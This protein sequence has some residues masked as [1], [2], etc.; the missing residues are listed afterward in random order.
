MRRLLAGWA[1]ILGLPTGLRAADPGK[2]EPPDLSRYLRW[3]P[4]RVRPG[5]VLSDIGY[6]DNILLN[7]TDRVSD[8]RATV[9]PSLDGL[10]LA[11]D[12]WLVFRERLDYTAYLR[13]SSQNYL[14]HHGSGRLTVPFGRFGAFGEWGLRSVKERPVDRE[15]IRQEREEN[16][17]R[18]GL[19]WQPGWR[20]DVELRGG[21]A[22]VRYADEDAL[23]DPS[24]DLD[25]VED[26]GS[27]E[28]RYLI[29]GRTRLTLDLERTSLRFD[30]NPGRDAVEL[31]VRPGVS[32]GQEGRLGGQLRL[33]WSRFE[34][35]DPAIARL[36]GLVGEAQATYRSGTGTTFLVELKRSQNF[37]ITTSYRYFRATDLAVRAVHYLNAILGFELGASTGKVVFEGI[38]NETAPPR[39]DH[40]F[41]YH[42]GAR[43]RLAEN[44][45]GRRIEYVVKVGRY[46]RESNTV[47]DRDRTTVGFDAVVGF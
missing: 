9:S 46:R 6:D 21:R 36:S 32:L 3:G 47:A 14:N 45:L 12:V 44:A 23:V 4:A 13:T 31:G 25:R 17:F 34:A 38:E 5:L 27:L 7:D 10:V 39:E 2:L 30:H 28:A 22:R 8:L 16:R 37:S 43:F 18:G 40:L 26:S 29:R 11:G 41:R 24:T 33:G 42:A 20:T 15:D 19:I 1:L 35:K